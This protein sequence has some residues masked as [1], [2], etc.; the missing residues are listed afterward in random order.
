MSRD[1]K[2]HHIAYSS[3]EWLKCQLPPE[4][5]DEHREYWLDLIYDTVFSA[6]LVLEEQMQDEPRVINVFCPICARSGRVCVDAVGNLVRC[7]KCQK[8]F[9]LDPKS[10]RN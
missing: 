9:R 2:K 1:R 3:L 8:V 6:L 4:M 7:K 10:N 5:S